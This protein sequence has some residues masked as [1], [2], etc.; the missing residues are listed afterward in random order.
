M[1][2]LK[3]V[4]TRIASIKSTRQIT[5]AMKMVSAAKLRKAQKGIMAQ[6]PYAVKMKTMLDHLNQQIT[7]EQQH[8]F[9]KP[10]TSE[11]VLVVA[12]TSNK[13]LCGT[14]NSVVIK[15]TLQ[16]LRLLQAE[17]I[18][19]E[20]LLIGKK[21]VEFFKKQDFPIYKINQ[22][23]LD[24][25][26]DQKASEVSLEIQGLFRSA[27]FGKVVVI[28]NYFKNAIMQELV[29]EQVLPIPLP[30]AGNP[31]EGIMANGAYGHIMEP[32]AEQVVETLV[33]RFVMMNL[34]RIFL[35][36]SAAEHGAR[37][38]AMNSA[39]D[40]ATELLKSLSLT[41]NKVRQSMITR[42]IMEIVAGAEAMNQ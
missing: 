4:R 11:K 8:V 33:P 2:N 32:S 12:I 24:P 18:S 16:H 25:V 26:T 30:E 5:S 36:A 13:G 35:D 15:Q 37:M 23:L 39:T 10:N 3:E 41:Y 40:N 6:R 31:A 27:A 29:V 21:A 34:Y 7:A 20:L 42:E 14:Y 17:N 22:E 38:T 28:Y 19:F 9:F 1:P